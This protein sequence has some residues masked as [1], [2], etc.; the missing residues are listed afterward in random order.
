[1]A[2]V[3]LGWELGGGLDHVRALIEI[4]H[5]LK[6]HGHDPVLALRATS[7]ALPYAGSFP[8]LKA[9]SYRRPRQL[10]APPFRAATF[11]D[12]LAIRGFADAEVL[13]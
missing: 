3:L 2:T 13:T 10:G 6:L 9:P 12:I 7:A 8:I 1:M 11:S 5:D 4:A